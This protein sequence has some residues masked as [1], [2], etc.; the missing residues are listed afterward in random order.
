[1]VV[2]GEGMTVSGAGSD[3]NPYVV[4]SNVAEI[5]T[6]IDIQ[7]NNVKIADDIHQLD[8]RGTGITVTPGTDEVVVTVPGFP[9]DS[10]LVPVP[11]GTIWM[12]GATNPPSGGWLLCDG[13]TLTI[14]TYPD[15]FGAIGTHFGGDGTSTFMLP[16]LM[17]RFPIGASASKPI[18]GDPGGDVTK[19]IA[20]ANL[21]PHTHAITHNH[22]PKATN[23]QGSHAHEIELS[24]NDG[25]SGTVRR[26]TSTSSGGSGPVH[27]DGGHTHTVDLG[28]FVGTSGSAGTGT[29]ID[30]MPPWLAVGF[31][32]KT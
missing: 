7:V 13:A 12:F 29:P 23:S 6:G 22:G 1:M 26:G 2:A 19:T 16:N 5:D 11:P 21:P 32:I 10:P 8:F 3:M 25:T 20:V 17:D 28:N 4:T 18:D 24:G 27:F 31:I 30:V 15:L 14:A 9:E